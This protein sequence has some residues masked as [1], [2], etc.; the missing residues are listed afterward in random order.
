MDGGEGEGLGEENGADQDAGGDEALPRPGD[1]RMGGSSDGPGDDP[2][3]DRQK[4]VSPHADSSGKDSS[5]TAPRYRGDP[6]RARSGPPRGSL[7]L[8]AIEAILNSPIDSQRSHPPRTDVSADGALP[9]GPAERTSKRTSADPIPHSGRTE[10]RAKGRWQGDA[11]I[12]R[13][14]LLSAPTGAPAPVPH[15]GS[16]LESSAPSRATVHGD[17]RSETPPTSQGGTLSARAFERFRRIPSFAP[18]TAFLTSPALG[19]RPHQ[20]DEGQGDAGA[21]PIEP[22]HPQGTLELDPNEPLLTE[23][24]I[25]AFFSQPLPTM[26]A[27]EPAVEAA[28]DEAD[29]ADE[30]EVAA[31]TVSAEPQRPGWLKNQVADL[32]DLVQALDLQA[33]AHHAHVGLE[34]ELSRLRQFT[35]TMGFVASPP[36]KGLQEF[37]VATLVEEALGAI[38]GSTP[39]APRILFRKR[40]NRTETVADKALVAA[41]IDALLHTAVACAGSGDVVRI[42]VEGRVGEL[43]VTEIQFPPGPLSDLHPD[44]ILTPYALRKI[45]PQ[46]GPNALAAAGA[47]AVGQGGDMCLMRN[48]DGSATFLF[49][50]PGAD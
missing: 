46:I 36:P 43:I 11:G 32:A 23:E 35:R 47:I 21:P 8:F 27:P 34:G 9:G 15:G 37:D 20:Q 45:L 48:E 38:A 28:P 13:N 16:Q 42:T 22:A 10:P 5:F 30:V 44:Q 4:G 7:D 6:S 1:R 49:E 39:N 12:P 25:N 3:T 33:R 14:A 18:R 2:E 17:P 41:A 26:E 50:L 24:E 40:G 29:E 19:P 31:D